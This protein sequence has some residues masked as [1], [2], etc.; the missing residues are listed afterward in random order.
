SV[1]EKYVTDGVNN[2]A[3]FDADD[4]FTHKNASFTTSEAHFTSF[5]KS[6]VFDICLDIR[7]CRVGGI[8]P[9]PLKIKTNSGYELLD[10]RQLSFEEKPREVIDASKYEYDR[11]ASKDKAWQRRLLDLSLKNNLLNFR[12]TRDCI[13]VLSSDLVSFC[14]KI[15]SRDKFN[16]LPN[17]TPIKNATFFGG[18]GTKNMGE[19]ISIEL[20]AGKMRC[21]SSADAL[22]EICGTLMRKSRAAE[23]EAGAKTLY[24]A[25]GFLKWRGKG[26]KEDKYAPIA[27]L[28]VNVKRTKTQGV[29]LELGDG[30]EVNTTLLEFLKQEF[31]IDVRGVEG[32]GLSPKEI[33]AVFRAK[34]A[35]MKGWFVYED[36][37]LS[38]FTFARYAM[39]ADVKKNISEYKKNPLIA[40]L[41]SNANK[42]E[43][44][45]LSGTSE[46]EGEPCE[47]IVP[48]SCDS[49]QYAAVA[50]SAKGTTFVLHG[51][52]GTGKS[53]TITNIIANALYNG[54][55]VLFV[56]EKQAALQVVKKRLSD[57]GIGD[58]CLE[59][60]SGKSADKGEIVRNIEN[61]LALSGSFDGDRFTGAG[62]R[63]KETRLSLKRP[64]DALHKKRRLGVSVYEGIV[65][66]LQNKNAPELVN[67]ESTFYDTL[68]QQKFEECESML[69]SAQAAANECGGVYRSPFAE[70][71]LTEC[72]SNTKNAVLCSAEVVLAEL[73]H[74]KNYL[75]L[76]LDTFNQRVSTF[77]NKKLENLVEIASILRSDELSEFF[78]CDED[79]F[80][81]FYNANLRYDSE[82]K[83]WLK[84][85]KSLPEI[86]KYADKIESELDNWGDN[87]RSSRVLLGVLKRINKCSAKPLK[88]K[89]ET[90]WIKRAYEIEKARSRI[91]SNTDLSSNFLSMGGGINDKKREE[92]L[93]PLYNLHKLC[94]S[95]FMDYNADAFNSVCTGASGGYLKP[96]ISGLISA[97]A[98]FSRS[99]DH[100]LKLIK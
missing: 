63:I 50:E 21:Y 27:L 28:P 25:F 68:T 4:L 53:Q 88:E 43:E 49:T 33:L 39:W 13:H 97:A 24:L 54:K 47:V 51:P 38:Q 78:E 11:T 29:A 90:E 37:Y 30:Y 14:E 77:T 85:F 94:G 40:S 10:D 26:D 7:R 15:E 34:T 58:F 36:I 23:E 55:R 99:L 81:K 59:L 32:K 92:F 20:K 52:P 18:A 35:N 19:L 6:G 75:G 48:L 72:D 17:T 80:Y 91:L 57:I 74:I 22:A 61:T 100:L 45:K 44:N 67:I 60:H 5:L 84:N 93:R 98:A 89:D 96:L 2:L 87:Y 82:V 12:Y 9:L 46:D 70:V 66:Y 83:H 95:V 31:G 86:S 79:A 42:L 71:N 69:I 73:K 56:A 3:V 65:Y 16:L 64:L 62:E 1:I 8:F 76:F 41:L